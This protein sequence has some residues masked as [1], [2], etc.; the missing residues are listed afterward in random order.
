MGSKAAEAQRRRAR[1]RRR[2]LSRA[3]RASR[4]DQAAIRRRTAQAVAEVRTALRARDRSLRAVA[5]AEQRAGSALRRLIAEGLSLRD[6]ATRSGLSVG[7]VRRLLDLAAPAQGP[8]FRAPSTENRSPDA[9]S[10]RSGDGPTD[11]RVAGR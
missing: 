6:A 9:S 8:G 5:A 10:A 11:A 7:V 3:E 2:R 4:V 1:E